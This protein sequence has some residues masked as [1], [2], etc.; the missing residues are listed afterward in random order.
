MAE[1]LKIDESSWKPMW[2]A[3]KGRAVVVDGGSLKV[4]WN[5]CM[6]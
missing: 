6:R 5:K 3:N 1:L 2:T 4:K